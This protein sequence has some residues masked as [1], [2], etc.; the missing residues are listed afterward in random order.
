VGQGVSLAPLPIKRVVAVHRSEVRDAFMP[1][2]L[3]D[4]G[5]GFFGGRVAVVPPSK[6]FS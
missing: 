6:P 1:S 5:A 3:D 2:E 4:V